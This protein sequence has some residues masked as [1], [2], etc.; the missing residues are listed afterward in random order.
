MLVLGAGA[1]S[2]VAVPQQASAVSACGERH[3]WVPQG[4]VA[5]AVPG[6]TDPDLVRFADLD[7]DGDDDRLLLDV[8]GGVREWR[9]D[10]GGNWSYRGRVALG[11]GSTPDRVKFADLDGDGKDDYL[12]VKEN[13]AVDGWRNE[14]GDLTTSSG[15][16]PGWK[17]LGQVAR[18]TGAQPDQVLFADLDGDGDDDYVT[19][20]SPTDA[21]LAWRNEGGDRPGHDGWASWGE[22]VQSRPFGKGSR[23][24][25]AD[26]DC[27]GRDDLNYLFGV[28]T[29]L[30]DRGVLIYYSNAGIKDG[31]YQNGSNGG[32]RGTGD[33]LERI[34]LAELNGD[35][36]ADYLVMAADGSL[37]GYLNDG[38]D[39]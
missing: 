30:G 14:G 10:R 15:I 17:P 25:F 23:V 34:M 22:I 39:W 38:G 37:T 6:I 11:T 36:R 33:P 24:G 13:G 2:S 21:V 8:I 26:F 32:A 28:K 16:E 19:Q 27:D 9:N 3:G 12:V 5:P 20:A 18:G 1:V 7:G 29:V 4:Q 35:G 31:V